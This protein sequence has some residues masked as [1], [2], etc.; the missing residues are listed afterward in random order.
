MLVAQLRESAQPEVTTLGCNDSLS[1]DKT[2]ACTQRQRLSKVCRS[3]QIIVFVLSFYMFVFPIPPEIDLSK[4]AN[5]REERAN[6]SDEKEINVFMKYDGWLLFKLG[7]LFDFG[8]TTD[9][10]LF[11][12]CTAAYP[13]CEFRPTWLERNTMELPTSLAMGSETLAL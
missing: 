5:Y 9:R 8:A 12:H 2:I 6:A 3:I 4:S 1:C 11:T 10:S 13:R 7:Y